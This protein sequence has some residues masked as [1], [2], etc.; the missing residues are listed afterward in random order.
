MPVAIRLSK[1]FYDRFGDDAAGELVNVL[2]TVD[3]AY[4]S[5]LKEV[6][7]HNVA[8]FDAKL[9]QR[10]A[11]SDARQAPARRA[12]AQRTA[13]SA[14]RSRG[15][16][17][18]MSAVDTAPTESRNHPVSSRAPNAWNCTAPSPAECSR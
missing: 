18:R 8:L 9:E 2:N 1:N 3:L 15:S 17:A 13:A 5:E 10:F 11:E 16:S 7:A 14:S 6:N 4:R 12:P